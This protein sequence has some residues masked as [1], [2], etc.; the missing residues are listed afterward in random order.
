MPST[1]SEAKASASACPQSIP[2]S[3][4]AVR[5]RSSWRRSFGWTVKPSGTRSS[6]SFRGRS[7]SSG[8]RGRDVGSAPAAGHVLVARLRR[9]AL[10]ERRPQP[11]VRLAQPGL[12]LAEELVRLGGGQ[13]SFVDELRPV[14]LAHGRVLSICATISGCVYAASSCSLWPKRR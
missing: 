13:H 2:P 11:L 1:S 10:G 5:R 8:T 7:R 4:S 3:S 14:E 9:N 12:D 6:S